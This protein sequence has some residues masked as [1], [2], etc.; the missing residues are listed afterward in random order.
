V[1]GFQALA[2]ARSRHYYYSPTNLIWTATD[3]A[4]AS[5]GTTPSGWY[6]DGTSDFGR[7]KRQDA[8]LNALVSRVKGIYNPLT[9]N[10]FLSQ[11]PQG[12]T[13]DSNFTLSDLI[14]LA[15]KFHHLNPAAI[16]YYTLPTVSAVAP[17]VGDVLFTDQP[18]AQQMLTQIFGSELQAPTNP[19]PNS[20]LQ[21]PMPPVVTTT[22]PVSTTTVKGQVVTPTTTSTVP[23]DQNDYWNPTVC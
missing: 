8:F 23:T 2:V 20:S 21:T 4:L 11:I 5:A 13:L 19:P 17:N 10:S 15:L 9:L 3:Q 6:Y 7:I 16:K 18:A 12:I 22:V 1:T 14:G